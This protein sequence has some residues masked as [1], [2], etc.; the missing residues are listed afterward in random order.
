MIRM[1]IEVTGPL[2]FGKTRTVMAAMAGMKVDGFIP[3][4][5]SEDRVRE[6]ADGPETEVY[7]LEI[8]HINRST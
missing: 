4:L 8:G 2:A 3:K 7:V 5:I 6:S 1:R